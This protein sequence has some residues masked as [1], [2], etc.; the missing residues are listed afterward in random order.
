MKLFCTQI[1]E[2][3]SHSPLRT[4]QW[5]GSKGMMAVD[6][7]RQHHRARMKQDWSNP[8]CGDGL[9]RHA[10]ENISLC[11]RVAAD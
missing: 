3:G 1:K 11:E 8:G 10:S 6:R 4:H 7:E 9:G 5:R 2:G